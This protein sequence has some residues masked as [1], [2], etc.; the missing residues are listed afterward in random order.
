MGFRFS[1]RI[2]VAP[3]IRLN[4]SKSGVSTSVGGRGAWLTFG[5]R[6]RATISLPGTGLSYSQ[7]LG[8]PPPR[9]ASPAAGLVP[10]PAALAPEPAAAAPVRRMAGAVPARRPRIWLWI[11]LLLVLAPLG[12]ALLTM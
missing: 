4:L 3:G 12:W 9:P 7:T 10:A 11:L 1:R 6:P 2:R 5:R 8:G